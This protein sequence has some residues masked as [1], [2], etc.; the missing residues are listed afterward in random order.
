MAVIYK[1]DGSCEKLEPRKEHFYCR[2]LGKYLC[3][4][5]E[6]Y[7]LDNGQ[8]L[9]LNSDRAIYAQVENKAASEYVK[10]WYS[11]GLIP[12]PIIGTAIIGF[13][14]E[15]TGDNIYE[16]NITYTQQTT[17]FGG[18]KD[19]LPPLVNE[20]IISV[21]NDMQNYCHDCQRKL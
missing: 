11:G 6:F 14:Y 9:A 17:L 8:V 18:P 16:Y 21:L 10:R 3:G 20:H 5:P 13:F 12:L 19:V 4:N 15:M 1:T 2:E 7:A